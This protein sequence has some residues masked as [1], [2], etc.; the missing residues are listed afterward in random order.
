M[1]QNRYLIRNMNYTS[2]ILIVRIMATI[3]TMATTVI[4]K[5][6]IM[7]IPRRLIILIVIIMKMKRR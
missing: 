4:M 6:R 5:S 1:H 3:M 2:M 7:A